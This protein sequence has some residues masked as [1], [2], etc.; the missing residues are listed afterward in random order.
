MILKLGCRIHPEKP[1]SD[2]RVKLVSEDARAYLQRDRSRYDLINFAY[3]DSQSAFSSMS[4]IR[5]D[6]YIYTQESFRDAYRHL[7]D[8]GV[9][10]VSFFSRAWWQQIRLFKTLEL[11]T[12]VKP[13]GVWSPN[14]TALT[15]FIGP[16]FNL[17]R[18][19]ESGLEITDESKF[20]EMVPDAVAKW[21][22]IDPTTDDWPFFFLRQRGMTLSYAIG[23]IFTVFLG[24]RLVGLCF[25]RYTA[26]PLGRAM[27]F[28]GA[29]FMLVEV[30]ALAQM[31]LLLGTT[32]MVN[33]AV[34]TGILVMIL[35]ATLAQIRWQFRNL[36]L[37]YG[38][39][40][41]C[42]LVSYFTPFS[43][44]NNLP[45]LA[46]AIAG[47]V[48]LSLPVLFSSLVFAITFS[49][50]GSAHNALGMNLLGTLVG[51]CLEY[52]SMLSGINALNLI[53]VALYMAALFFWLQAARHKGLA[54]ASSARSG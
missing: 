27:F 21:D 44:L 23:L 39:L 3:I 7:S 38:L 42:L 26:D 25:G 49:K 29:A 43:L 34:I 6:N 1:Y 31:G 5:L 19:Q 50:V 22:G 14:R 46:R 15:Y 10:A 36:P 47:T 33:S 52:L 53:A 24:W 17:K 54:G 37:L 16:G 48:V 12:G 28:L 41:A 2:P 9:M 51:G 11:A 40:A 8:D 45:F 4:S 35:L 13:V 20:R 32:W 30:R 18:A